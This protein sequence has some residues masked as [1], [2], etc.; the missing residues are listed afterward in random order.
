M[1]MRCSVCRE[2]FEREKVEFSPAVCPKCEQDEAVAIECV[3]NYVRNRPGVS[4]DVVSKALGVSRK[5][6]KEY[7]EADHLQIF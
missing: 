4:L 7:I 3:R 1:R 6:I 2:L 5:K